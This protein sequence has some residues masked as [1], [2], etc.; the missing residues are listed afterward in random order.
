[1]TET[2]ITTS[3]TTVTEEKYKVVVP[4]TMHETFMSE[5]ED[6]G[7][8]YL[9]QIIIFVLYECTQIP[10]HSTLKQHPFFSLKNYY[11]LNFLIKNKLEFQFL[12]LNK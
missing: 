8:Q 6:E 1:M 12:N 5:S 3:T 4:E 10:F 9:L 7:G 2:T 11:I